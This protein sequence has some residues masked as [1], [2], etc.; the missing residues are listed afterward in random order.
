MPSDDRAGNCRTGNM[1]GQFVY[2]SQ[3]PLQY[4]VLDTGCTLLLQCIGWLSLL[5]SV[6]MLKW[7]S[8]SWLSTVYVLAYKASIFSW[9]L[10][11]KL[12]GLAYAWVMPHSHILT[13][14]VSMAWTISR[15]LGYV[16]AWEHATDGRT[17]HR[18]LLRLHTS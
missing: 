15:P 3:T 10:M 1:S 12:W 5:P 13:V 7:A 18:L 4:M 6:W 8:A 14:S 17:T 9:I 2:S 16:C 11:T